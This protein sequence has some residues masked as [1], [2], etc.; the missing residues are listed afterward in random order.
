MTLDTALRVDQA[1]GIADRRAAIDAV[2]AG[3]VREGSSR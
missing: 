3:D 1:L 2:E